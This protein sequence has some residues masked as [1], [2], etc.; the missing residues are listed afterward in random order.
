[1]NINT[2]KVA[3]L[4]YGSG[5]CAL[6]YQMAWLREFR[7]IF[8]ASTASSAAVLA[9][10]MGGLGLGSLLLGHRADKTPRPLKYYANL[11]LIIAIT[12]AIT[13]FL[14]W[15]VRQAYIS[16]GGSPVLGLGMATVVRLAG[17]ALVLLVPT[18]LMGGTLPAA[19]R[20]VESEQD[21]G[22]RSLA[23]LYGANTLGAVTGSALAT[24]F[25]LETF[26]T[27]ITLWAACLVNIL[28]ALVARSLSA[29]SIQEGSGAAR[30][31]ASEI[32]AVPVARRAET[33]DARTAGD[34]VAEE[35]ASVAPPAFVLAAS[36]TVG[37]AFLL[38]ELVWYRMLSP[39]LGGSTF[40]F[41]L[42][43]AVALMGIGLGGAAYALF[44]ANRPA[45]LTG[46]AL[47]CALE[48]LFIA[49]P[50]A[51]GDQLAML[52]MLL[53]SLMSIGFWGLV[54]GWAIITTITVLPAAF[55]AGVQ[56]PLLIAL[57]GRGRASIGR[58]VGLAYAWNTVGA[59]LGSLG[60][61]FGILPALSAVGTWR[62]VVIL[63]A[64]L[65]V[66]TLALAARGAA[67]FASGAN[68][69]ADRAPRRGIA[70]S[71][72]GPALA[73]A[74]ALLLL[75][76]TGPTAAWRHAGIGAGRSDRFHASPNLLRSY[77]HDARRAV[78]RQW[79]GIE[80]SVAL[81]NATGYAFF[82]NGK[83][84][85][86][87]RSDAG[88][89]IIS[90]L[91]GGIV[92]ADPKSTMI[93]GLGTG[94]TAGWLGAVPAME[95][96]DVIELEPAILEI[97]RYCAEGNQN[98]MANPKVHITIGDAREALLTTPERYDLIFSEP[99]NPYRAG[100]ASLYTQE[101]YQAASKR[102]RPGG[103]FLQWLQGY[104][105]DGQTVRTVFATLGSVFPHVETWRTQTGDMLL[106]A[107]LEP[108]QYDVARMRERIT[109]EPYRSALA[110]I[111]R[112]T[113]LEGVF[114]HHFANS[115]FTRS[116]I[117]A[118][119]AKDGKVVLNTDDRN[120]V[121]FAFARSVGM[122]SPFGPMQLLNVAR[123][124]GEL[125]PK[126]INGS[127]DWD[128]VDDRRNSSFFMEGTAPPMPPARPDDPP[129]M[130][131]RQHRAAAMSA[132]MR[133]DPQGAI[134]YWQNQPKAPADLTELLFMVTAYAE[135][136]MDE[137]MPYI[138]EIRKYQPVEADA[139]VAQLR[140][141]Q[142][143]GVEAVEALERAFRAYR[144]DPWP[145]VDLMRRSLLLAVDLAR[146]DPTGNAASRL[147]DAIS[148]PFCLYIMN[149]ARLRAM[150][151]LGIV[152][153]ARMGSARTVAAISKMEPH[154][155]WEREFLEVRV[156]AYDKIGHP[157]AAQAAD[158]LDQ[159]MLAEP[160]PFDRD[161]APEPT[162]TT[163]PTTAPT[164]GPTT[165]PSLDTVPP[166]GH[167]PQP[168]DASSSAPPPQ[169][170]SAPAQQP[171]DAGKR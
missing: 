35:A 163:G 56:F 164:T 118:E 98:V 77:I 71:L 75:L 23:L 44:R 169:Q 4:L 165:L 50:F 154:I 58:H 9:I 91:I 155:P 32:E 5:T 126:V 70:G 78:V 141:R 142:R 29:A 39:I 159:Y 60:G 135:K 14:L 88:T 51:L 117:R 162:P 92:H 64:G 17:A 160:F 21:V 67:G 3:L 110:K 140:W 53:R 103:L 8:G 31:D 127:I 96:V 101:F 38:M 57:L 107:S 108:I 62:A 99:S 106:M 11:E 115:D 22:R 42:I 134:Q 7:L 48:A 152:A 121:E 80:S 145:Q 86:H 116:V 122:G 46:F 82:V 138:E 144:R 113:D 54:L 105:V 85:G 109:Q 89:Q 170:P 10:F 27:H 146:A 119:T 128:S 129:A 15:G 153:D 52:S 171:V 97:A 25:L 45:T 59:I 130:R 112:V 28:I 156:A 87:I 30:A 55:I 147:Y 74:L 12:A 124:R 167:A 49:I 95:R 43:L 149:D 90:G 26:G 150:V 131:D 158:D 68:G 151:R 161:L 40:T 84:D 20:S 47:T 94:S 102:L 111:W 24:F 36:A 114:G 79:D 73:A 148:E 16:T 137:A 93:I 1:M 33:A 72:A 41:G 83:S 65:A 133:G 18:F 19:A 100:I 143:K 37:F 166:A 81:T 104:E 63:L 125:Q 61:G 6:I 120:V 168:P 34:A 13:P 136:S 69:P 123:A 76:S 2:W 139:L 66:V 157:L 132:L